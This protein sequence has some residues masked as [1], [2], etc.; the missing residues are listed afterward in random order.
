MK[1][2]GRIRFLG[3]GMILLAL[4]QGAGGQY[5][6]CE[7][8]E[9]NEWTDEEQAMIEQI[10]DEAR[11]A[12]REYWDGLSE[13]ERFRQRSV[14]EM[15]N[16]EVWQESWDEG[17]ERATFYW[18]DYQF[19]I[20]VENIL[21]LQYFSEGGETLWMTTA[22]GMFVS[23]VE[24]R[25]MRETILEGAEETIR[26]R[27][28]SDPEI[29]SYFLCE[30]ERA[31]PGPT[32]F[33]LYKY[34]LH[35]S[36]NEEDDDGLSTTELVLRPFLMELKRLETSGE[37]VEVRTADL[38]GFYHEF[39]EDNGDTWMWC[40]MVPIVGPS[41][42]KIFIGVTRPWGSNGEWSSVE[43]IIASMEHRASEMPVVDMLDRAEDYLQ[44]SDEPMGHLAL[45]CLD[46]VERIGGELAAE[47][48]ERLERLTQE[49][50]GALVVQMGS[51]DALR[52][53]TALRATWGFPMVSAEVATEG[54]NAEQYRIVVPGDVA[55]SL[56]AAIVELVGDSDPDVRAGAID[57]WAAV[58]DRFGFELPISVIW[59]GLQDDAGVVRAAAVRAIYSME[60]SD[61]EVGVEE[62]ERLRQT[63]LQMLGEDPDC[64]VRAAAV[65]QM[66]LFLEQAR[67]KVMEAL[68]KAQDDPCPMVQGEVTNIMMNIRMQAGLGG[69]GSSMPMPSD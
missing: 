22:D 33:E 12:L 29:Q 66:P 30:L 45:T 47:Q 7:L 67:T 26:Q 6:D 43:G 52:R 58:Y 19:E 37:L 68:Q 56:C 34:L 48:A 24:D 14:V 60:E 69:C 54:N 3:M 15:D 23:L 5:A 10:R 17:M 59:G 39:A 40:E 8:F 38:H 53:R 50:A 31:L 64:E 35:T 65:A 41:A 62:Y 44:D 42:G 25:S 28:E 61:E 55:S 1:M 46:Y 20:P 36:L 18:R 9:G 49:A 21:E 16:V 32:D 4:V 2:Q 63:V 57:A 27:T 13:E 51:A 11:G